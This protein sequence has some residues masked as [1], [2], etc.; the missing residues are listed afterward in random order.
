MVDLN[1][2][3]WTVETPALLSMENIIISNFLSSSTLYGSYSDI[4]D[5]SGLVSS[6]VHLKTIF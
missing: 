4:S 6:F 1:S 5:L 2:M 3:G